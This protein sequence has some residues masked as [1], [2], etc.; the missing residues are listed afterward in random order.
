MIGRSIAG[1]KIDREIGRGGMATVY[2]AFDDSSRQRVAVK[3]IHP[4]LCSDKELQKRFLREIKIATKLKHPNIVGVR[5]SG[6]VDG[7]VY[8]LMDFVDGQSLYDLEQETGKLSIPIALSIMKDVL[9][10][11]DYAHTKKVVHRDLKPENVLLGKDGKAHLADF[12]IAKPLEGTKLTRTGKSIGTPL[13][14]APEQI[15]GASD[16][17]ARADV[18]AAGVLFYEAL[19]GTVPFP[20]KDLVEI[21]Y[22][23][24]HQAPLALRCIRPEIPPDLELIV[25]KALEKNPDDR[26]LTATVFRQAVLDFETGKPRPIQLKSPVRIG[27]P[28]GRWQ[29]FAMPMALILGVGLLAAGAF[30]ALVPPDG[31]GPLN[32]ISSLLGA[33]EKVSELDQGLQAL[34]TGGLGQARLHFDRALGE[35]PESRAEIFA[36][37]LKAGREQF[38][39]G[40]LDQAR[41][42]FTYGLELQ[43]KD[44]ACSFDLAKTYLEGGNHT[45]AAIQFGQTMKRMKPQEIPDFLARHESSLSRLPKRDLERI[46]SDLCNVGRHLV[47]LGENE[48]AVAVVRKALHYNGRLTAAHVLLFEIYQKLGE[49]DRA[50]YH[51][52]MAKKQMGQ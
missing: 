22:K 13:Y 23:H 11:L 41:G 32:R 28:E 7:Q 9:A 19:S 3:L 21:G 1:Y 14:M 27:S 47:R 51:R 48:G 16:L 35:N 2:S 34:A 37:C 26:W 42:L 49:T 43:P 31:D 8:Y 52:R 17:D 44:V 10:A 29:A 50:D 39:A 4:H 6:A 15:R 40:R 20:G 18:Y 33:K 5:S 36:V 46:G 24:V 38:A 12:G 45:L 25:H 30:I